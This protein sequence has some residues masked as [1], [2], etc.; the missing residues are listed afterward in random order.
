[1]LFVRHVGAAVLVSLTDVETKGFPPLE[2]PPTQCGC[3]V[4]WLGGLCVGV[5]CIVLGHLAKQK[6]NS[7]SSRKTLI[8]SQNLPLLGF[9][10]P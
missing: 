1:L 3:L 2:K 4:A 6:G 5:V 9:T 7:V 8:L 10:F